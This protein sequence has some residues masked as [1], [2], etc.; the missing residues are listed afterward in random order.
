V[1]AA[2]AA[3]V[4]ALLLAG[5][6]SP[7]TAATLMYVSNSGNGT[8]SAVAED[9]SV[10]TF[11]TGLQQPAG[12][13][14]DRWGNLYVGDL[15]VG[16][17]L[18]GT[19]K[20]I[21]PDG[22]VN[23]W[24]SGF[25]WP[26]CLAF[27]DTGNLYVGC[28]GYTGSGTTSNAI[29]RITP[30]GSVS[31]FTTGVGNPSGLAFDKSGNLFADD[32]WDHTISKITPDG[33]VSLFAS[34]FS[35][36]L[37]GLAF[38]AVGNLYVVNLDG[39]EIQKITQ[40]SS[41]STFATGETW[42]GSL[43]FDQSGNLYL[44]DYIAD[45]VERVGSAGGTVTI[46]ATGFSS[47]NSIA[48]VPHGPSIVAPPQ[49]Q[50][51]QAG[52]SVTFSVVA[53][54]TPP[55]SFQWRKDGASIAGGTSPTLT[56]TSVSAGNSG[57]YSVLIWNAINSAVST[58]ASLAVLT[59]GANGSSPVQITPTPLPSKPI[60]VTKL[61]VITHGWE[62]EGPAADL[63]W[64]GNMQSAI[65]QHVGSDC[66]VTPYYWVGSTPGQGAWTAFP[67]QALDNAKTIGKLLGQQIGN[68]F[69]YVH[70]IGHSAGA[71]LIQAAADAIRQAS[72]STVIQETFLD[73][74]TGQYLEGRSEYGFNAD[75]ADDYFVV[76]FMTDY[77]GVGFDLLGQYQAAD[78]TS[79][80][81]VWA[82]NVDVGGTLDA[83]LP[84]QYIVGNG[85]AGSTPSVN[86]TPSHGSPIAFY[87]NSING[88]QHSCATGYGFPL[89][90]E[91]GGSGNWT[92]KSLNNPPQALCG[93]VSFSQNEQ[94]VRSDAP[95]VFSMTP[96]G[97]SSSGVSFL[98]SGGASL[99][100]DAP[101]WL[102]V[103]VT[104]TNAV[105]FVQFDAGFT[106]TN[107]AQG[108]L[109]VYWN[110][111]QVG[112]VDER[113]ASASLQTYRFALPGT[114]TSGLY[115]LTFRLDSF[116]NSSSIVVT[117]VV[118]GFV[119]VT[120]P[121]TLG[122]SR[123]NGA[124]LV[125][126]RAATNFTYLIQSSTNLV[127]WTPTALLLNTNGTAQFIDFAVTNSNPRFY[128]AVMP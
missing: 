85:I 9:G 54:G 127:D 27:D 113:V 109:T 77:F 119:G 22:H 90:I 71:G 80:Q 78:S 7:L 6:H 105:N 91:A 36:R 100:S 68:G 94:P 84:V 114:V 123:T 52:S 74:Y 95:V 31:M 116:D 8:I 55:L 18:V 1:R 10:S 4:V 124:P 93:S 3:V 44:S 75:W 21:T 66:F 72:Q 56:L 57:A 107:A 32:Y 103:G 76:D 12:L 14:L 43:A 73:P 5:S 46:F 59:D 38:D 40:G 25:N 128:R 87:L 33:T 42:P 98:G 29:A 120:Q 35:G 2:Q 17:G 64:M 15:G 101:A 50:T 37:D 60:G 39:Y 97:T 16:G 110:T 62:I 122:I 19:I 58:T 24:A 126:L 99:T 61:V 89:S 102:A 49:S 111:N 11:A 13:A 41:I 83:I 70:L 67:W 63:S 82:Y 81:L 108:L 118:T 79:G 104:V 69:Q 112:M 48:M 86:T 47:P 28:G 65:L 26:A 125:Q 23:T 51:A 121:I 106:D 20:K 30:G 53:I 88:A 115:T 96:Y 117:N 45:C 34:G 92:S